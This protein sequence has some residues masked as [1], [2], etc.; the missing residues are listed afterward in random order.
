MQPSELLSNEFIVRW[1]D[2]LQSLVIV[3][4]DT[5]RFPAPHVQIRSS[6]LD[7][8]TFEQAAEFIGSRLALLI[9]QL[10]ARYVDPATG[11][12]RQPKA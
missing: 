1:D 12:L 7:G 8:M 5:R 2:A 10:R 9:P 3:H 4:P 11:E 6:T